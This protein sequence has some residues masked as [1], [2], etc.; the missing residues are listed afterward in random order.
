M[1]ALKPCLRE[2]CY[3]SFQM[4]VGEHYRTEASKHSSQVLRFLQL[5]VDAMAGYSLFAMHTSDFCL[6]GCL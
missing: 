3:L 4:V 6:E 5:G 2:N 1:E